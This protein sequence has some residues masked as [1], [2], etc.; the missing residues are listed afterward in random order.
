MVIE[1]LR[2]DAINQD[3]PFPL[4]ELKMNYCCGSER[5]LPNDYAPLIG[6]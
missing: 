1:Y 2:P 5:Q 4:P 6:Y 3:L